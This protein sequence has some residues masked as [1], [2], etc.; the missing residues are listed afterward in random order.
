M[1]SM[2]MSS[3][4]SNACTAARSDFSSANKDASTFVLSAITMP[5]TKEASAKQNQIAL[6][7]KTAR[8]AFLSIHRLMMTLRE[9]LSPSDAVYAALID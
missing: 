6:A 4:T 9:V 7:V 3:L 8:L 2:A 1:L 5:W